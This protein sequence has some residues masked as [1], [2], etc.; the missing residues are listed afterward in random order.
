MA[1]PPRYPTTDDDRED[2]APASRWVY[3]LVAAG[4]LLVV[5]FVTLHLTGV[6]GPGSH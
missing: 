1:D 4:I 2:D 5:V 6:L 3:V